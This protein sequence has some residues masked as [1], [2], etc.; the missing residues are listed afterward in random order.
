MPKTILSL[1]DFSGRW[2]D[3]YREAGYDVIQIDIKLG[4]D[5]RKLRLEDIKG[6]IHGM[7]MAPV[8]TAFSGAGAR[9]WKAKEAEGDSQLLEGLSIIDACLRL[10]AIHRPQWWCMENPV[11]RATQ[12]YGNWK[13]TF[14]PSDYA[15]WLEDPSEDAYT[16]RTCLWG[17]FNEPEK[18]E[19][20][21]TQGSKMWAKYGGK[22]ERTKTMRSL[23]P[24]G[25]A[26]AFFEAN[27]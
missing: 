27:P 21:A 4:Q 13:M 9:H 17:V 18:K 26:R 1:C 6:P 10:V 12:F 20:D 23:T 24:R 16:K 2:S 8:C 25:F 11:G 3:P 14:Q 5:L 22:S 7:L 15:G 19:V